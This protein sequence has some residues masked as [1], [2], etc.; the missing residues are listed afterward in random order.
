VVTL[1][2]FD[3]AARLDGAALLAFLDATPE[4]SL[5]LVDDGSRGGTLALLRDLAAKR[6]GRID[7]LALPENRGKA[8]AVRQ[9]ILHALARAP[10]YVGYWDAD[11]ATPLDA[12]PSFAHVLD[13]RPEI[14]LVMGAR[15]ALLG[16]AVERGTLRHYVGRVGATLVAHVLRMRVYD[17][18][19]GAKL[20]RVAGGAERLFREPFSTRWAFDVELL[21][22]MIRDRD[23]R[24]LPPAAGVIYEYPLSTWREVPGSKVRPRDYLRSARDL[25]RIHRRYLSGARRPTEPAAA[26]PEAP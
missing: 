16:R 5:V 11:L 9:G 10:D 1:P 24:G 19:C 18:Q 12:I 2:C 8:E 20:L 23:A 17:T 21:A 6:P 4:V 25:W 15:I 13:E 26:R 3:E 7:V 22:R 14:D